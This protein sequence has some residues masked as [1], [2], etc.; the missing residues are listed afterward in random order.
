MTSENQVKRLTVADIEVPE[1]MLEATTLAWF[2]YVAENREHRRLVL[3][4]ALLWLAENPPKMKP[5]P[6]RHGAHEELVNGYGSEYVARVFLKK[7]PALPDE[8]KKLLWEANGAS[9]ATVG[10]GPYINVQTSNERIIAAWKLGK[11]SK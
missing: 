5:D 4:S 1:G 2:T 9:A 11:E 8:V 7:Q 3:T 10:G 6:K